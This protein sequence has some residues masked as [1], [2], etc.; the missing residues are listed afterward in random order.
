MPPALL[1]GVPDVRQS[2]SYTCG[3]SALQAVL[4]YWGVSAREDELASRLR[5]TPEQGTPPEA[6]VR[7]ARDLGLKAELR[8]GLGLEELENAV[9]RG[10]TAI[11]GLQAWR[12]KEDRPWAD[13]W[14]DGHYMVLLGMDRQNLYFED[15]SLLGTRG[16]IPRQ[17]FLDRWH[18]YEGEAPFDA[19]DRTYIHAAIFVEGQRP[20]QPPRFELVK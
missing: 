9:Q 11:V 16:F 14:E 19:K 1:A 4:A 7:G 6:I 8:E 18:D 15:P 17:E 2:T 20:A 12:D 10:V 13:N 3:P 5:T